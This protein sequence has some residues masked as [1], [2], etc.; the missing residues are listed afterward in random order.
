[1]GDADVI[2]A[3]SCFE[4]YGLNQLFGLR[5]GTVPVVRRVRGLADTVVD[6]SPAAL[7]DGPATGFSF[8]GCIRALRAPDAG[9]ARADAARKALMTRGMAQSYLWQGT[10]MRYAALYEEALEH[11]TSAGLV[12]AGWDPR[13]GMTADQRISRGPGGQGSILRAVRTLHRVCQATSD[14]L[15]LR[16]IARSNACLPPWRPSGRAVP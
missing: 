15:R 2:T 10:A 11:R 1:M 14:D 13:A 9:V 7:A 4:H 6:A 3:P 8:A 12:V 16:C 5:Y